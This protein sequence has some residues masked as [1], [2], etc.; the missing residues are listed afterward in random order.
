LGVDV[1]M[2]LTDWAMTSG[3]LISPAHIKEHVAPYTKKMVEYAHKFGIPVIKHTD[4]NIWPIIDILLETGID[5]INP[6]DPIAGMDLGEG[7]YKIGDKVCLSGNVDNARL[8]VNGTLE[9]VQQSV[10][11]CIRKAGNGG[12]YICMSSNTI[13]AKVNPKLYIAMVDAVRKFGK[14][15]LED[16]FDN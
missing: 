10:K 5:A 14:Y 8:L 11:E 6:F 15:P 12:G 7:K 16:E 2:I 13:H 9:E 1:F 3:P 4:G